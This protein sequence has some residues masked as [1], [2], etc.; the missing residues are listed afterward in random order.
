MARALGAVEPVSGRLAT[1]TIGGVV[2]IDDSYNAN[3]RSVRVALAAARETADSLGGRLIA[4]LGDMLELGEL[5]PSMHLGALADLRE[6]RPDAVVLAG[7]EFGAAFARL[8]VAERKAIAPIVETVPDSGAAGEI[9]G[10]IVHPGDIL[11]VKGSR[12]MAMER[13]IEALKA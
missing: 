6:T 3:P 9:V 13:V 8:G 10:S 11:L 12:G 7:P 4:S 2:V 1:R 5:S